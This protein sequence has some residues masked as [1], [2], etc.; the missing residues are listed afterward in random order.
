MNANL[1]GKVDAA[2]TD[3]FIICPLGYIY[4]GSGK[5][6]N[7][8]VDRRFMITAPIICSNGA[9]HDANGDCRDVW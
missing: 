2:N 9:Q 6:C 1:A 7:K 3:L 5:L 8:V 4:P